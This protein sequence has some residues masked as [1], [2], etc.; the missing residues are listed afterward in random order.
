MCSRL[1][2]E[3][4]LGLELYPSDRHRSRSRWS[5]LAG[6]LLHSG[7]LHAPCPG[8]PTTLQS[9]CATVCYGSSYLLSSIESP[10]AEVVRNINS[11]ESVGKCL[12]WHPN[13][14]TVANF[15]TLHGRVTLALAP[16]P[17]LLYAARPPMQHYSL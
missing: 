4:F 8:W 6:P 11:G 10:R 16:T 12:R 7:S 2:R 13:V 14:L 1:P 17:R 15:C 5:R 3:C 9:K